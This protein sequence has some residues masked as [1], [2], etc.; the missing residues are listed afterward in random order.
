MSAELAAEVD[1]VHD[2]EMSAAILALYRSAR[3]HLHADWGKDFDRPSPR[4]GT[5]PDPD[6]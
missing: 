6:R 2:E 4:A 3:P 5:R 1:T